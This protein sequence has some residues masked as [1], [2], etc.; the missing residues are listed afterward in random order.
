MTRKTRKQI[1]SLILL[2]ILCATS[3]T[4]QA[5]RIQPFMSE[6]GMVVCTEPQ[7]AAA[8]FEVLRA[9][10]NAADAAVAV[11]F[12]LAVTWPAAGNLGGG[13]FCLYREPFGQVHALD[14]REAAP[15]RA[16]R[17]MFMDSQGKARPELSQRSLLASGVPGSVEGMLTTLER[18]GSGKFSREQVI[19]PALRLA[20]EGMV[21]TP[22]LHGGL[23][24]DSSLFAPWAS[25]RAKYFPHGPALPAGDTLRQIDLGRVLR[26][27]SLHG[28]EGFYSGWVA[29]SLASFM[30]QGGGLISREDLAAYRCQERKPTVFDFRGYRVYGMPPPSSGGVVLAQIL[31]L[32]DPL[33][34]E[35]SGFNSAAYANLVV[36]AE[37][38]AY[39]DRNA[40][41]ADPDFVKVPLDS[42]L[43]KSYLD[44]RRK[45]IPSGHAGCSDQVGPGLPE[46]THTTHF[47]VIDRWGGAAAVTTTINA[48]FGNGAV[49]PGAGFLL[50]NEMDDFASAPGQP[51]KFGLRQGEANTVAPGKRM[52]SSMTPTI[53]TRPDSTGRESLY[54]A[55]GA[56]GGSTITTGVAQVFLN[57]ALFG[58][59]VRE[60]V[61]APRFHHQHYPDQIVAEP[62]AFSNDTRQV[63]EKMGYKLTDRKSLASVHAAVVL[64]GGWFA[65]WGDNPPDNRGY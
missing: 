32:L 14:Y 41:L 37:R 10:G 65:G 7:A 60:A 17:E 21:V 3:T 44:R 53:V 35:N 31:G 27:I 52:L 24:E 18:F 49:V 16:T 2:C 34:P 4:L 64:P 20:E 61:S 23:V 59:N 55:L 29:D 25:S 22:W 19:A 51:N 63:L 1:I 13:G 36:E 30:A 26:E 40:L 9:G 58:M 38:L 47:S 43:S 28:R 50:N 57:L 8:G 15:A 48:S 45:L 42:L 39:A 46:P 6:V 56:S 11:G 33:H 54:A 62:R 5:Q 12:A